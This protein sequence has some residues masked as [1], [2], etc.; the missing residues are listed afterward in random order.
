MRTRFHLLAIGLA[1]CALG[2]SHAQGTGTVT[3]DKTVH[4]FADNGEMATVPAGTYV[5]SSVMGRLN[6]S[7]GETVYSVPAR[8]D[9]HDEELEDAIA[10]SFSGEDPDS[11]FIALV[12][13]RSLHSKTGR[14]RL[15]NG[16]DWGRLLWRHL[17]LR[18]DALRWAAD[19]DRV[20][21]GGR[22]HV[23]LGDD[24][25]RGAG[26]AGPKHRLRGWPDLRRDRPI[27]D[28]PSV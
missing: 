9:S 2:V 20:H 1:M 26:P 6:L 15:P 5:V 3:L 18:Y 25:G 22:L 13:F 14:I 4:F 10:V 8:S 12:P 11:H 21:A 24:H 17:P 28:G 19:N 27:R 7:S 23:R 16:D